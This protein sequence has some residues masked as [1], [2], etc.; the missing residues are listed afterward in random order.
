M[1]KKRVPNL[2]VDYLRK[3]RNRVEQYE[4]KEEEDPIGCKP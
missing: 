4:V 2:T 3:R 1:K